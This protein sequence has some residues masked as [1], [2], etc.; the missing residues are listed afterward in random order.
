[1]LSGSLELVELRLSKKHGEE[2]I[3][4][5]DETKKKS[6]ARIKTLEAKIDELEKT[7]KKSQEKAGKLSVED[8]VDA[9]SKKQEVHV[10]LHIAKQNA[11]E[12]IGDKSAKKGKR[13]RVTA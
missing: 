9:H 5:L 12:S 3:S 6:S 1:M 7:A 11:T 2:N 13:I 8:Y 4:I 10:H